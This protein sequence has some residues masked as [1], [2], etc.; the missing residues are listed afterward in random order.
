MHDKS[1]PP[2]AGPGARRRMEL[3]YQDRARKPEA[4]PVAGDHTPGGRYDRQ[5]GPGWRTW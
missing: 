4:L 1:L 5:M 2:T 3:E